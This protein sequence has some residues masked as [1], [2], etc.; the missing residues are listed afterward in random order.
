M[1]VLQGVGPAALGPSSGGLGLGP[2]HAGGTGGIPNSVGVKFDLF[3]NQGEGVDST[4][5]YL[6]GAAPTTPAT[7]LTGT[8]IDLHSGHV[9]NV[10]M[11]YDGTTLMVTIADASTGASATQSYKVNIP[12]V[13]GSNT[14]FAGFTGGTGG[15]TATRDVLSW[16]YFATTV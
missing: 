2:D 3:N 11:T 1:F 5:L 12:S 9:F 15:L 6:N 8:G 4:G 14:A 13:V 10:T 7:D 16:D